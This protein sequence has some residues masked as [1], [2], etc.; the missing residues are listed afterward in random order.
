MTEDAISIGGVDLADPATYASGMPFDAFRISGRHHGK[1]EPAAERAD[2]PGQSRIMSARHRAPAP[3][4]RPQ[5]RLPLRGNQRAK[6]I[7][8]S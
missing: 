6:S 8:T 7:K 5:Q 3:G 4:Y 1:R 2:H